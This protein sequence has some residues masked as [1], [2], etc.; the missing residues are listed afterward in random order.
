[1]DAH[2]RDLLLTKMEDLTRKALKTGFAHSKFLS[3][4]EA[5][6]LSR[7]Y[8]TRRDIRFIADG[9][10]EGAE[11]VIALFLQPDWG[12]FEREEVLAAVELR[13]R[14]QDTVRHQDVL[15]SVLGLG[16]SREVM[17]DILIEPGRAVFVCLA[18]IADY[19]IDRIE[20]LGRVGVSPQRIHLSDLPV[21][22]GSLSEKQLT[23]ASLRLDALCAVSFRLSR[24][25]AAQAI[26]A[27][28]VRLNHQPCLS[29]SKTVEEGAI[30]SLQ[31]RGRVKLMSVMSVT[32]KGR[33][34]LTLGFY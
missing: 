1:M 23:V 14:R 19:V 31:G 2:S 16:L 17:G 9:G 11:R 12:S 28:L 8:S 27:G 7:A 30:I 4:A 18:S 15:G 21:L 5:A 33:L 3:P 6:E 20:K 22:G 29:T 32:K 13:H 10:F 25:E 34:R 24:G 26:E